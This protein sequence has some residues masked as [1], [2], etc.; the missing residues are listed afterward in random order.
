MKQVPE[1]HSGGGM[2]RRTLMRAGAATALTAAYLSAR[3]KN[4]PGLT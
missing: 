1:Q 4:G 3:R 2:T